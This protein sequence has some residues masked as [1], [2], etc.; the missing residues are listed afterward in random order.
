LS[1]CFATIGKKNA[2]F[3]KNGYIVRRGFFEKEEI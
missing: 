2:F 3:M 1:I